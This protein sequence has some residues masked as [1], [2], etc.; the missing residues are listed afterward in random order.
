MSKSFVGNKTCWKE[1]GFFSVKNDIFFPY[2]IIFISFLGRYL[3]ILIS[4]SKLN[5]IFQPDPSRVPFYQAR[6]FAD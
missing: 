6:Y 5:K 1:K 2:N 3:Q 4:F